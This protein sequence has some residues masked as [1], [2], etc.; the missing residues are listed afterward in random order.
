MQDPD[1]PDKKDVV[2][3]PFMFEEICKDLRVLARSKPEHKYLLVTGLKEDESNVVAV[4]GD[5]TNDAR[6]LK[7]AHVGL[8]MGVSGTEIAKEASK[9]V[10]LDDNLGSIITSLKWGR[11]IYAGIRK[12]LQFQ[13]TINIVALVISF[14]AGIYQSQN[15]PISAIQMLWVNL[16][17]DSFAALALATEPPSEKILLERPLEKMSQ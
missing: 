4:T 3:N 6:V 8:A 11:N 2:G 17:M 1:S 10:L 7:K 14:V 13:L 5:S 12:Y 16:I 15:P 9:I